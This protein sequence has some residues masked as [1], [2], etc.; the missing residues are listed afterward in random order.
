MELVVVAVLLFG[1]VSFWCVLSSII[2]DAPMRDLAFLFSVCD[3][4]KNSIPN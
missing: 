3:Q 4:F 1:V 2:S